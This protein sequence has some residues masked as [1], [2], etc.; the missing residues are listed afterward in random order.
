VAAKAEQQLA[1]IAAENAEKEVAI[2]DI[3]ASKVC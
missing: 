3:T 1:Q 2:V